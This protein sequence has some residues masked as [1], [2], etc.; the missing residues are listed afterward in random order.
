LSGKVAITMAESGKLGLDVRA[1]RSGAEGTPSASQLVKSATS[2][3]ALEARANV[4][5]GLLVA[6]H[7]QARAGGL[8]ISASGSANLLDHTLDLRVSVQAAPAADK[9]VAATEA[10][11]GLSISGPWAEPAVRRE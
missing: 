8:N 10:S 11:A 1:I 2:V 5:D 3:D 6:E 9:S 4:V 7:V